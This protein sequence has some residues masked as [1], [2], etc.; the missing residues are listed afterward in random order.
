MDGLLPNFSISP[1]TYL[2]APVNGQDIKMDAFQAIIFPIPVSC[3][4]AKDDIIGKFVAIAYDH[5]KNNG[6]APSL[7]SCSQ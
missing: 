3:G 7:P 5:L 2:L 4:Q 6:Q 1:G